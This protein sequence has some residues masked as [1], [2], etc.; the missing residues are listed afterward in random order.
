MQLWLTHLSENLCPKE[1]QSFSIKTL[2]K[3][4]K[5]HFITTYNFLFRMDLNPIVLK[6]AFILCKQNKILRLL[7]K[8]SKNLD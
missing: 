3:K 2:M 6:I 1:I 8:D 5:I 4:S 7:T